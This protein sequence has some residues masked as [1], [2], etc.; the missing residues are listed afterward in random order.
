[1]EYIYQALWKKIVEARFV[2]YTCGLVFRGTYPGISVKCYICQSSY[3][4]GNM[5]ILY[6]NRFMKL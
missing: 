2:I 5:T 6:S 3:W 4:H 1:M